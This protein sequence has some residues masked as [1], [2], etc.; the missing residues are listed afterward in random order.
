MVERLGVHVYHDMTKG[1]KDVDVLMMLRLQNER[2]KGANLPSAEEYFKYYG[3]TA[4]EI[5][6]CPT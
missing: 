4:G 5:V 1:L 3:L 6:T 2:M